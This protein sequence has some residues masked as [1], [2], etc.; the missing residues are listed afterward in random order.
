MEVEL[1]KYKSKISTILEQMYPGGLVSKRK[2][3]EI[4]VGSGSE[5]QEDVLDY[6]LGRI[7]MKS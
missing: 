5:I 2:F 7:A 6:M 1:G 3:I 4:I